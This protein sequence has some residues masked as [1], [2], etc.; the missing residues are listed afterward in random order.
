MYCEN[1]NI[2]ICTEMYDD[3]SFILT[4]KQKEELRKIMPIT[5]KWDQKYG[6]YDS[7]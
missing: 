6:R 3:E 1:L 2:L 7:K 4:N 5:M